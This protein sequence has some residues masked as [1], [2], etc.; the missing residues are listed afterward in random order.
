MVL[1]STFH[2]FFILIL[3]KFSNYISCWLITF[4]VHF[5]L[6]HFLFLMLWLLT[7]NEYPSGASPTL[8]FV[9][10]SKD[11]THSGAFGTLL[12]FNNEKGFTQE[13][14]ES[15]CKFGNTLKGVIA[16]VV[17]LRR[18]VHHMIISLTRD[19]TILLFSLDHDIFP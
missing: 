15:V 7:I 13:N 16:I 17:I 4:V 10:T 11:F 18:K 8:E 3:E 6:V 1:F 19:F 9:I 2:S 5:T 12:V 14:V